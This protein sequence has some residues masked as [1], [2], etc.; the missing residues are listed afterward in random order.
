MASFDRRDLDFVAVWWW[1]IIGGRGVRI[2]RGP[3]EIENTAVL[4]AAAAACEPT[5]RHKR[6]VP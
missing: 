3:E 4:A 2:D 5:T 1:K 6:Q